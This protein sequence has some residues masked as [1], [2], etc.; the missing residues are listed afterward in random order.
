MWEPDTQA[1]WFSKFGKQKELVCL[2]HYGTAEKKEPH[3]TRA[4][5]AKPP[6]LL[7]VTDTGSM[8]IMGRKR[9]L[10]I[11]D[12]LL[13]HPVRFQLVWSKLQGRRHLFVWRPVPPGPDF[14]AL[15]DVCTAV[16]DTRAATNPLYRPPADLLSGH[17]EHGGEPPPLTC[18]RCVPRHWVAETRTSPQAVWDDSGTAGRRGGLWR[19]N[20]LGLMAAAEGHAPPEGPF[21]R[22]MCGSW[23]CTSDLR[24]VPVD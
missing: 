14:V 6:L 12:R 10:A 9:H 13:P 22:F 18:V 21:Y 4:G 23:L 1:G 19:I 24:M 20:E 3:R 11:M 5:K 15:G 2:G 17:D 16:E 8:S 7:E